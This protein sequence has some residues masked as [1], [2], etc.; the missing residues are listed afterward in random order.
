[1]PARCEG[2]VTYDTPGCAAEEAAS[3]WGET[4][5]WGAGK[6]A[7]RCEAAAR[8]C[9]L[10]AKERCD[11]IETRGE[12]VVCGA[13]LIEAMLAETGPGPGAGAGVGM[14]FWRAGVVLT[15]GLAPAVCTSGVRKAG[16]ICEDVVRTGTTGAFCLLASCLAAVMS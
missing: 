10:G 8:W 13:E 2:R 16:E 9:A 12:V 6:P 15:R 5:I 7:I 4:D 3:R 1:M 11:G 14:A